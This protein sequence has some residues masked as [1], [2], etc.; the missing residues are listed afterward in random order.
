MPRDKDNPLDLT[1]IGSDLPENFSADSSA[2][3]EQRKVFSDERRSEERK[4][5]FHHVFVCFVRIAAY[6]FF[7]VFIA[8]MLHFVLPTCWAWLSDEQIHAIDKSLFSGAIGGLI[9]KH[10]KD[11]VPLPEAEE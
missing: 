5:T 11:V 6:S 2:G 7:V 1:S 8:R 10:L 9:V 4:Q 3:R